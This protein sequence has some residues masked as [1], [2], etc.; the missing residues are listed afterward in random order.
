MNVVRSLQELQML[1][2]KPGV[3]LIRLQGEYILNEVC[4]L[5]ALELTAPGITLD[6]TDAVIRVTAH[7]VPRGFCVIKIPREAHGVTLRGMDIRLEYGGA[8]AAEDVSVIE[9][10]GKDARIEDCRVTAQGVFKSISGIAVRGGI[11]TTMETPADNCVISGNSVC[12][13]NHSRNAAMTFGIM[14]SLANSVSLHGN[15]VIV[16]STADEGN[17]AAL[18]NSGRFLQV[19]RNGFR[20]ESGARAACTGVYNNGMYMLFAH[21]VL[22]VRGEGSSFGYICREGSYTRIAHNDIDV[23]GADGIGIAAPAVKCMVTENKITA[24]TALYHASYG[25]ML[26]DNISSSPR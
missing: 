5:S 22:R 20:A 13:R 16:S 4:G 12:V 14:A 10:C 24:Q 11:N 9:V 3:R 19:Y 8:E 1:Q 25:T 23:C 21:N 26:R 18:F 17:T 2:N 15:D 7:C 6:G